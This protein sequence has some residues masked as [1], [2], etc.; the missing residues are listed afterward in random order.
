MSYFLKDEFAQKR[1]HQCQDLLIPPCRWKSRV[2]LQSPKQS[3]SILLS[4]WGRWGLVLVCNER[5]A[6]N[7][8]DTRYVISAAR[9]PFECITMCWLLLRGL[10]WIK[11]ARERLQVL[12]LQ[13]WQLLTA[14]VLQMW[15]TDEGAFHQNNIHL[16]TS[17]CYQGEGSAVGSDIANATTNCTHSSLLKALVHWVHCV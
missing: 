12:F 4:N 17:P 9:G 8:P 10:R 5:T 7:L 11:V 16:P 13:H 6:C 1:E 2:K 3:C 15:R 14:D